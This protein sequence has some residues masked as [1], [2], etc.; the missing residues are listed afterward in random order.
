MRLRPCSL[1]VDGHGLSEGVLLALIDLAEVR[2]TSHTLG[3]ATEELIRRADFNRTC[4]AQ[5]VDG[6]RH[7]DKPLSSLTEQ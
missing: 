1:P 3:E 4:A 5:H 7:Q 6:Q 2:Q